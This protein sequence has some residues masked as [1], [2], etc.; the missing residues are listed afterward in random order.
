[1]LLL[2]LMVAQYLRIL[3]NAMAFGTPTL[4]Q[5]LGEELDPS[6][7]PLLV[8]G[9]VRT[10]CLFIIS[11]IAVNSLDQTFVDDMLILFS[12]R[13]QEDHSFQR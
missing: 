8:A 4:M 13:H 11:W 5:D 12:E 1:M 3:E 6:I 10:F 7:D 2:C 9:V